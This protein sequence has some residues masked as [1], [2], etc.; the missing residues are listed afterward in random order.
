MSSYQNKREEA[1]DEI[2]KFNR[3]MAKIRNHYEDL[4]ISEELL[5]KQLIDTKE[6][7]ENSKQ[8]CDEM[9]DLNKR[10]YKDCKDS[11]AELVLLRKN[12]MNHENEESSDQESYRLAS[13]VGNHH[14]S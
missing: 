12:L 1:N 4:K 5:K 3:E 11:K 10:L 13:G 14:K 9:R 2:N 6:Q 8:H 7:L